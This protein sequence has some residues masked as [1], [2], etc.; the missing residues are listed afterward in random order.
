[1]YLLLGLTARLAKVE[2][3]M[4]NCD[5]TRWSISSEDTE[6]AYANSL[7]EFSSLRNKREKLLEQLEEARWIKECLD[8][9]DLK[10]QS[11]LQ[12]FLGH[13]V[14]TVYTEFLQERA[15][16]ASEKKELGDKIKLGMEQLREVQGY[17]A[18]SPYS[19]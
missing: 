12:R 13:H 3:L 2:K 7:Q 8:K 16:L 17:Q 15:S 6:P 19:V 9:R 11:C 18:F 5:I 1:M 14:V 4:E 10:I